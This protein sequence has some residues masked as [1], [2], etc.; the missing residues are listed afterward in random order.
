KQAVCPK[1][2]KEI[3][4]GAVFCTGCGTKVGAPKAE[5]KAGQVRF[6]TSCGAQIS[7]NAVFC[8]KCGARQYFTTKL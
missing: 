8:T 1:C 6:C 7:A 2:G 5:Q 3:R 4:P